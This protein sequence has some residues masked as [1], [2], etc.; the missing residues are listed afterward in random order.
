MHISEGSTMFSPEVKDGGMKTKVLIV[1]MGLSLWVMGLS[2]SPSAMAVELDFN[3]S[4]P[5][6]G[7][8]SYGGSGGA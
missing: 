6:S 7:T 3:L 2:I 1:A 8:I 5:T 4:A